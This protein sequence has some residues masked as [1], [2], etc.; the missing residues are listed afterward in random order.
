M[1]KGKTFAA[2]ILAMA[3][4]LSG[5]GASG[6]ATES[7]VKTE[8][9]TESQVAE[10]DEKT[11]KETVNVTEGMIPQVIEK[12]VTYVMKGGNW[13]VKSSEIT[14][15]TWAEDFNIQSGSSIQ[16]TL[17]RFI[18]KWVIP[19]KENLQACIFIL[20]TILEMG[21]HPSEQVKM[22]LRR[23]ICL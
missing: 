5:C 14:N 2:A 10:G 7:D 20:G 9:E 22:E 1:R 13:E 11:E 4:L 12:D 18:L 3:L 15:W 21:I 23:W 8:T 6:Q 17:H 19:L 16:K